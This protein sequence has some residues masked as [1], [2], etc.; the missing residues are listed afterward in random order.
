MIHLVVACIHSSRCARLNCEVLCIVQLCVSFTLEPLQELQCS[1]LR[2]GLDQ[3][4]R[5]FS[6]YARCESSE[7]LF[8]CIQLGSFTPDEVTVDPGTVPRTAVL[9][10]MRRTSLKTA[11]ICLT[12]QTWLECLFRQT[13]R[14]VLFMTLTLVTDHSKHVGE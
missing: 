3:L 1:I 7:K 11:I 6:S 2:L 10:Q 14:R 5:H 4:R 12:L 9:A 13:T 8:S